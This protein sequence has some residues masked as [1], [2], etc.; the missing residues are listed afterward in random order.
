MVIQNVLDVNINFK[1]IVTGYH[2]KP[3]VN[4]IVSLICYLI[5]KKY[6]GDR[7]NDVINNMSTFLSRELIKRLQ[8]YENLCIVNLNCLIIIQNICT[9]L[10]QK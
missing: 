2:D 5:Y 7:N 10:N 6:L 1:V 4:C 9:T 8:T 3:D